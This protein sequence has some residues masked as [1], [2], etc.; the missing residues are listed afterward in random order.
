MSQNTFIADRVGSQLTIKE[1][2][3]NQSYRNPLELQKFLGHEQLNQSK[4]LKSSTLPE[5]FIKTYGPSIEGKPVLE[6][7]VNVE[8]RQHGVK[9]IIKL[10]TPDEEFNFEGEEQ[11]PI[12]FKLLSAAEENLEIMEELSVTNTK[13]YSTGYIIAEFY[14][15]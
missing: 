2:N 15:F 6:E 7:V 4:I 10:S 5:S 11:P 12:N 13:F 1:T 8:H 14:D 9:K 3:G